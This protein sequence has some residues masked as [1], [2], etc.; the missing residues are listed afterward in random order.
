M[1]YI[2]VGRL[3]TVA[4]ACALILA[5]IPCIQTDYIGDGEEQA[6]II[7]VK[8][9]GV[10]V[11]YDTETGLYVDLPGDGGSGGGGGGAG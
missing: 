11:G 2:T 5:L 8:V 3:A 7:E 1:E 9:L 10:T 6:L 4:V